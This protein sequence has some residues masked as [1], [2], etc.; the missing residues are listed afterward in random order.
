MSRDGVKGTGTKVVNI[1]HHA[2]RV[3]RVVRNLARDGLQ[4]RR[5]G[6]DAV[7]AFAVGHLSRNLRILDSVVVL[8]E[9]AH[10]VEALPLVRSMLDGYL[11]VGWVVADEAQELDRLDEWL[12]LQRCNLR[13]TFAAAAPPALHQEIRDLE[14]HIRARLNARVRAEPVG[15]PPDE[16]GTEE[17]LKAE[18]KRRRQKLFGMNTEELADALTAANGGPDHRPAA[19]YVAYRYGSIAAHAMN[20]QRYVR[21]RGTGFEFVQPGDE[22]DKL[23]A[24]GQAAV[25]VVATALS[26][27]QR[28][29]LGWRE[30]LEALLLPTPGVADG[31]GNA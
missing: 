9:A 25:I 11:S 13:A 21:P 17:W 24:L 8:A 31:G 28:Y 27:S 12:Y 1:R 4:R 19:V 30:K 15:E 14:S 23:A 6:N 18:L 16:S 22:S 10:V 7:W 20:V 29:G 26:V 3:G 2:K 5:G